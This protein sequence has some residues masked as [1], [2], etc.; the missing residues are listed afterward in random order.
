MLPS[1]VNELSMKVKEL[2]GFYSTQHANLL[3][4]I[5]EASM[6]DTEYSTQG[7]HVDIN[8]AHALSEV[9]FAAKKDLLCS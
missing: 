8:T 9:T 7:S 2:V 5:E 4:Q 6:E 1:N 3:D